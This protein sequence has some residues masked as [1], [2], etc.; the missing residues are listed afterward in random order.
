MIDIHSHTKFSPDSGEEPENLVLAAI[1]AGCKTLGFSEH[2]DYD[3]VVNNMEVIMTDVRAYFENAM[4][5][6]EKYRGKINLLCG[7]EF[8][9][10]KKAEG[11]YT[12]ILKQYPFDYVINSV[13]VVKGKD[14]YFQPY[15][16][17]KTKIEAYGG[18]IDNVALSVNACFDY[19]IIGHIGYVIRN[20]P[21]G[22]NAL[23]YSDYKDKLDTILRDIIKNN[24]ALEINTN[25]REAGT[26]T[27]PPY[28][29][30]NKYYDMGGRLFTYG[31]DCHSAQRLCDGYKTVTDMLNSLRITEL[32]Y[33]ENKEMKFYK[34]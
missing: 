12:E 25:V 30:I 14:C 10:D 19:Q 32:A 33:F 11:H 8:G 31:S 15:F 6:K 2:L 27:L 26:V 9:Y 4:R 3:Y 18:Y 28:G 16:E 17:G 22:D 23:N 20:A 7:I 13:H 1:S 21:Y 5:L 29:I 34:I 24:K